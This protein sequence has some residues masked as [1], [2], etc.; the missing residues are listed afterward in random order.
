MLKV[1]VAPKLSQVDRKS[2]SAFLKSLK[3]DRPLQVRVGAMFLY[4][5]S[6]VTIKS[7]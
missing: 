3:R 4:R 6:L 2:L 7:V 5:G 1:D